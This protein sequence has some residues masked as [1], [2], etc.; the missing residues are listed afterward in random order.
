MRRLP[1]ALVGVLS[2]ALAS[3]AVAAVINGTARNDV[4]RGTAKPDRITGKGGNDRIFGGAGNDVLS[5]GPGTDRIFGQAGNDRLLGGPGN[6]VLQ[7]NAGSDRLE[8][9]AG[10][11]TIVPGAGKDRVLCG[12]GRDTVKADAADVVARDCEVV[13]RPGG[14]TTPPPTE[15]P[16]STPPTDPMAE[17]KRLFMTVGCAGCHALAD[18]G[19]SGSVGPNLDEARPSKDRVVAQ[20]SNGGITMPSFSRRLTRDQIEAIATYVS[21]VA[22]R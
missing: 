19:A 20:V 18:A 3:V 2:L 1:L 13:S 6:D 15:P 4:L 22:G 7:G 5:G 16:P 12:P 8:G 9:G 14:G 21:T 10:N 11:D 17:G